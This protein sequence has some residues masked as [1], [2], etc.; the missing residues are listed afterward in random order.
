MTIFVFLIGLK[1]TV[2]KTFSESVG[3]RRKFRKTD[4][5]VDFI[6]IVVKL[7]GL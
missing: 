7:L 5:K 3:I 4:A 1:K 2:N 6:P